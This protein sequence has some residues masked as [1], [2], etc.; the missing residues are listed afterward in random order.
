MLGTRLRQDTKINQSQCVILFCFFMP[1]ILGQFLVRFL[2]LFSCWSFS[3]APSFSSRSTTI[4]SPFSF[5]KTDIP[6]NVKVFMFLNQQFVTP[7]LF[8][9]LK[10]RRLM[11]YA[12]CH[13]CDNNYAYYIPN[14][15]IFLSDL[16]CLT[17]FEDGNHFRIYRYA[18]IIEKIKSN[19][20]KN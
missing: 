17:T 9:K 3:T 19:E 16:Q 11:P 13:C 5:V 18:H 2:G 1:I 4:V 10:Y 8:E 12:L 7:C 20:S 14:H 15:V 6:G